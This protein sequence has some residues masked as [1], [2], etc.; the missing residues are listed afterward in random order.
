MKINQPKLL[1][2][3]EWMIPAGILLVICTPVSGALAL[4]LGVGIA[5]FGCNR[6]PRR[7]SD[8]AHRL[9]QFSIMG[10]GAGIHL[11]MVVQAGLNGLAMTFVSISLILLGG[12]LCAR[13][14]HVQRETGFLICVGTAIC[15][16]SAIAAVSAVMRPRSLH[17]AT[18]LAVVFT[19]NSVALMVFPWVGHM[20][21][22][23]DQLFAWWAALAIH[24]TSSVVGAGLA[25]SPEALMLATTVKLARS[26]WIIPIA[27]VVSYMYREDAMEKEAHCGQQ[28]VRFPL[29]W[30]IL[31][32]IFVAAV[33][34]ILPEL[35]AVG[36]IVFQASQRILT[37]ALFLIGAG[38]VPTLCRQVGCRPLLLGV[39]LWIPTS[40]ISLLVLQFLS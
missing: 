8:C 23:S 2:Y 18:A 14:L 33:V 32:F 28:S 19:L 3:R 21:D 40:V 12:T 5:Q 38:M 34:W 25:Y 10:L 39:L 36:Q 15:G 4:G 9:L 35:Q 17:S 30:F 6:S 7:W 16:G 37:A 13:L 31:G 29:P 1:N 22:L 11:P 24:D 27:C 20:L 26:L